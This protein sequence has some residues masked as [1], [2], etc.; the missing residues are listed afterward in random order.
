M[1]KKKEATTVR[2]IAEKKAAAKKKLS[3]AKKKPLKKVDKA[4]AIKKFFADKRMCQIYSS[5]LEF[6]F[7]SAE[8]EQ[9]HS[10][11]YCKDFLQDAV[12]AQL[13]KKSTSIFGFMYE[14]GKNP[15]IDITNCR[16]AV[17]LRKSTDLKEKCTASLNFLREIDSEMQKANPE[18]DFSSTQLSFGGKYEGEGDDTWVFCGGSAWLHNPILI[19]FYSLLIRMGMTYKGGGWRS[20][21]EA[22]E[23]IGRND[24]SYATSVLKRLDKITNEAVS[25]L[26]AKEMIDNYPDTP[27]LP[28][29]MHGKSG[30]VSFSNDTI[31]PAVKQNW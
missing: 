24:R 8:G 21:F 17:R 7:V 31:N 25:S 11:A 13:R 14:Y 2:R 1:Q 12:W 29:G 3:T 22:G 30:I 26:F 19:S 23:L 9:C 5:G 27:M 16:L 15:P 10:F 28:A 6:A 4:P 18:L 20:H